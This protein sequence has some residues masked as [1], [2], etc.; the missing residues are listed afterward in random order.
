MTG[1][2]LP[3]QLIYQGKTD[4][5]H[6][7]FAFPEEFHVTHTQSHWSNERKIQRACDN[8]PDSLRQKIDDL[9]LRRK[10]K[11]GFRYLMFL[12]HSGRIK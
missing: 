2:F 5:C 10:I 6:P 3:I 11:N 1:G 4:C 12:R 9:K 7:S 8:D